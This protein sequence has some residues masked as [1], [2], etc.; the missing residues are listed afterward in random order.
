M[1]NNPVVDVVADVL[2][3]ELG[4]ELL[5][6]TNYS[7]NINAKSD[8][9]LNAIYERAKE[10]QNNSTDIFT[11]LNGVDIH[12]YESE[13]GILCLSDNNGYN[14]FFMTKHSLSQFCQKIGMNKTYYNTCCEKNAYDL[15]DKNM[16]YWIDRTRGTSL[17]LRTYKN[18]Y[19]RGVLSN[20][21]VTL[22]TPE[23]LEVVNDMTTDYD[24]KGAVINPER[25]H[26]R[27]TQK[28]ELFDND[29]LFGGFTIDSSDVGRKALEI[30]FFI[31]KQV[32]MNGLCVPKYSDFV[33]RQK[34]LGLLLL[35]FKNEFREAIEGVDVFCEKI[36]DVIIKSKNTVVDLDN[37]DYLKNVSKVTEIPVEVLQDKVIPLAWDKYDGSTQWG[38]I[39]AVTDFA[40][41][42]TLERRIKL[43][44]VA[45][46]LLSVAA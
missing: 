46:K 13:K 15:L 33:Y 26:L 44:N 45:G 7:E 19:V 1:M 14:P 3:E 36:Q 41:N 20:K 32:C 43:E 40:Q 9:D 28:R 31:Y 10:I 12:S 42:Y 34:H 6:S 27:F 38:L 4:I 30:K 22:D 39:N 21:F 8:F 17:M 29:D 11:T 18:E 16:N 2:A 23:I 5:G 24:L 35:D 37:E 25:L